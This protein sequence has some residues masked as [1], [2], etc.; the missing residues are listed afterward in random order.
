M[1]VIDQAKK[2]AAEKLFVE[3]DPYILDPDGWVHARLKRHTW[4]KQKLILESVRDHRYTAVPSCHGPG[5]SFI[6]S[7]A[8]GWWIDVHPPGEAIIVSTAPTDHQVK[9][10]LWKEIGRRR[11]E[12]NLLGRT[13][14]E[15]KWYRGSRM[16]DEELI[17]FGRK[18]QDYDEVAFQ[19][20]HEKYVLVLIDEACGVPKNLFDA[21]ETLLTSEL[22]RMIAIGNPDDPTSYFETI[23]RPDSDWNVIPIS[24]FE[25]PNFTGERV[26]EDVALRLVSQLWVKERQKKWGISSPLYISKVLG[27]FPE[28]TSDTLITPRMVRDAQERELPGLALGQYGADVAR[29][30]PDETVVYRNRGGRVRL[31]YSAHQ[32]P[33]D[34]TRAAFQ[35]VLLKH[36]ANYIPMNVDVIGIGG[37]VVDEMHANNF[38]VIGINVAEPANDP[39]R[40]ANKRAE[41]YWSYREMFER[42]E[43]DLDPNDEDLAAQLTSIKWS[44]TRKGQI[45]IESKDDMK[46]RGLPSPDRADASMLSVIPGSPYSTAQLTILGKTITGDLLSRVM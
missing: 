29:F 20:V 36:G 31:E 26:P 23:C 24:A 25:T 14:L 13:T 22:C 3:E 18:P 30:G 44:I 27:K 38:N 7:C 12:G 42:E 34:K 19:G 46:R 33:T 32:Q 17:G 1:G 21:L 10:V 39:K 43:I 5:K 35:M 28:I 40:F 8:A 4:S 45:L 37:G 16:I 11:R 2:R 9:A 15:A 6:A 41:M